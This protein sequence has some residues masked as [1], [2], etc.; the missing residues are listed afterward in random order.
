MG[1]HPATVKSNVK[2]ILLVFVVPRQLIPKRIFAGPYG[3]ISF[4]PQEDKM[5]KNRLVAQ[6]YLLGNLP[7]RGCSRLKNR[8]Y[9][10]PSRQTG[11]NVPFQRQEGVG[12]IGKPEHKPQYRLEFKGKKDLHTVKSRKSGETP[13]PRFLALKQ[14][15][16]FFLNHSEPLRIIL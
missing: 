5:I 10:G 4:L 9:L 13:L 11:L 14:S 16:D 12:V 8:N 2:S 1:Y 15:Q 3:L 6:P 7:S